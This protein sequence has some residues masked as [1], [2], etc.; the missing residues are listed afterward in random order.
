MQIQ[1]KDFEIVGDVFFGPCFL[2][3]KLSW[4]HIFVNWNVNTVTI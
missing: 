1:V 4:C 2:V 3:D